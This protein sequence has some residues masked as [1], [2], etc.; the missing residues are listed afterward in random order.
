MAYGDMAFL[1]IIGLI[2]GLLVWHYLAPR[3][4][5]RHLGDEDNGSHMRPERND[6]GQS[7]GSI[8]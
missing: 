7:G 5:R 1:L 2:I 4:P 3:K 8:D 6:D